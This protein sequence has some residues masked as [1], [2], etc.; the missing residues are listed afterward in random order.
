MHPEVQEKEMVPCPICGMGL[1]PISGEPSDHNPELED[2]SKRLKVCGSLALPLLFLAMAS[3]L[4][5]EPLDAYIS[6]QVRIWCE[7]LLSTPVLFWG[8]YPFLSRAWSSIVTWNLNMFT[9]IG[10]GTSVAYIYSLM[11]LFFPGFFPDALKQED[12]VMDV[13][14]E[15]A[16]VIIALTIL[17][18]VLELRAR[19]RTGSAIRS[20][21]ELSPKTAF[22]VLEGGEE[23]EVAVDDIQVGDTL[24]VRPGD[25]IA[26]DGVIIDGKGLINESMITG[27][28]MPV[29]KQL[30]DRAIGGTMNESGSF[31][32]KV[33]YV[34]SHT[35][36]SQIVHM[37]AEAQRSR[38]PIQDVADRVATWFVPMVVM[39]STLTAIIWWVYGGEQALSYAVV[40]AVAVLIIA[41]PC[42]IGLATPMSIMVA[43]GRGAQHGILLR[44]AKSLEQMQKVNTLC[45]D[46]TGTLTE[47]HPTVTS[48]LLD[49]DRNEE[50]VLRFAASLEQ[51]SEH[52]LAKAIIKKAKEKDISLQDVENFESIS[53]K[54]VT[55]KMGSTDI[56]LGNAA[57]LEDLGVKDSAFHRKAE[58][59]RKEGA[60][61]IFV[62]KNGTVEGIIGISDPI[63][64]STSTAL[65]LLNQMGVS[66]V[67]LTG[68]HP[69]TAK[70]VAG[71][72]GIAEVQA[73]LLPKDKQ[74]VIKRYREQ[75]KIVAMVGDGINDAPALAE[76]DIGIAMGTGTDIAIESAGITLLHGDL[77]GI[78]HAR[79]LS[80][81]TVTNI[82]QNLFFAF[83]YNGV[84]IPVAA[85]VLYP[86]MGILLSP[87]IAS[88][89]MVFSSISVIMNALR[90]RKAEI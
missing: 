70:H 40:N 42:A 50:E 28:P 17:G 76:A 27:E 79:R 5:G 48:I 37:V 57:L 74:G 16:A 32:M 65:D 29:T 77:M 63:R 81:A 49:D 82:K 78:V 2:M 8:G 89:A 4:P 15:A 19:A 38:A 35:M 59:L 69:D 22:L 88:L 71:K 56:A 58:S 11:A 39:V 84:G 68:D 62:V 54:G 20:L 64:E 30:D 12:G 21:L 9:L 72:L 61:A 44:H 80:D 23:K 41:C 26:V 67:M 75:G 43:T 52:P 85:G 10:I 25:S 51:G 7:F 73:G 66:V 86:A 90:L 47:G 83:I 53:G 6:P 55:G 45:V 46:K 24:R 34:G 31:L 33:E 36:L 87:M 13:Y 1:E 14:F 18:Q 60:T 3:H